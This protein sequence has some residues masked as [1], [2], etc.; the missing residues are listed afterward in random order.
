MPESTR[1]LEAATW[2]VA[3]GRATHA[4]LALFQAEP[5]ASQRT[6]LRLIVDTEDTLAS[7]R[8]LPTGDRDQVVT[9][10]EEELARLEAILASLVPAVHTDAPV[11]GE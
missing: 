11:V 1:E 3:E 6:L 7:V 9:D 5:Q 10:F 2:A 8:T 4:E